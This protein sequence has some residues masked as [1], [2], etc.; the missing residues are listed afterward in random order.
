MIKKTKACRPPTIINQNQVFLERPGRIQKLDFEQLR[1]VLEDGSGPY[2]K[3]RSPN[4]SAHQMGTD[5]DVF[6]PPD[7]SVMNDEPL[8]LPSVR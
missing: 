2:P 6:G 1:R 3:F 5:A 8:P 4:K 7:T